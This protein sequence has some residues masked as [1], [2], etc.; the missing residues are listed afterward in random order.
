MKILFLLLGLY[1]TTIKAQTSLTFNKRLIECEN[2]WVAFQMDKKDSSYSYGFIYIDETAGPTLDY[3]GTFKIVNGQFI[4]NKV[5]HESMS[6]KSRLEPSNVNVAIIPNAKF[7]D[8][9]IPEYPEWLKAYQKDTATIKGLYKWGYWYNVW[10]ECDKA[11]TYL[12][13]AQKLDSNYNGLAFELAYAYNALKQYDKAISIAQN[14]DIRGTADCNLYK[15][16]AYAQTKLELLEKAG[17][18]Y[19][20]MITACAIGSE[21]V[22]RETSYNLAYHYYN[23]KNKVKFIYWA[24][25]AKKW[26]KEGSSQMNSLNQMAVELAK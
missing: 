4:P 1:A 6:F 15:E 2:K 7:V 13:R 12:E 5:D 14:A 26:L 18:T 17:E 11:L 24:N 9:Q 16:L 20:K 19:E 8:L 10:D 3:D 23:Q 22:K 25:E 21:W